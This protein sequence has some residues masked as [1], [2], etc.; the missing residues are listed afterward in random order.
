MTLPGLPGVVIGRGPEVAWALTNVM[1]DDHDLFLEEFDESGQ[2]VRRGAGWSPVSRRTERLRV[3]GGEP[4]E[5]ELAETDVGPLLPAEPERGLPA[6]SLLWAMHRPSD[7]LSAF[8]ALARAARVEEVPEAIGGYVSPAQNLVAADRSG[9]L[10]YTI[11]GRLPDRRKGDGRLPAPGWDPAYGW[12]GLAEASRNPRVFSPKEDLLITAN[13]DLRPAGARW[14]ADFD[15]PARAGSLGALLRDESTPWS[16]SALA[17]VQSDVGYLYAKEIVERI[18]PSASSEA[19]VRA[20]AALGRWDGRVEARGTS[21]LFMLFERELVRAAMGD[22]IDLE[23]ISSKD[24]YTWALALVRGELSEAWFDDVT[25]PEAEWRTD[26][27]DRA[28]ARAWEAGVA[29]WGEDV[30]DWAWGDLHTLELRHPMGALPLLGRVANRG[31]FPVPGSGATVN[32]MGGRW[33][34]DRRPVTYGA[35]MRWIADLADPDGS[36]AIIPGGQAGHPF[37]PHFD[38]QLPLWLS[39]RLHAVPWS[40]EAIRA[41]TVSTLWLER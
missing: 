25:T 2:N 12:K 39:G 6:R 36:L 37:D 13:H 24:D 14:S 32:A 1:L 17:T 23:R 11:L 9:G 7:P 21:A 41:A 31:P 29:R 3:R 30:R 20:V 40:E 18:A 27:V 35:S 4:V 16:A 15:L 5:I 28:L 34:G 38:D 19:A 10:L 33:R 26:I 8:L 22:E